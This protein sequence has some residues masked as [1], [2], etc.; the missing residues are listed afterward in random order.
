VEVVRGVDLTVAPGESVALVGPNGAGKT[1]LLHAL[2]GLVA[3]RGTLMV[4]GLHP[5][6]T[7]RARV[8][9]A[10]ALMPQRPVVPEG[11][12]VTDLVLLGRTPHLGRFAA[13]SAGDR[14]TADESLSRLGIAHLRDRRASELSGGELQRVVL[15]RALTQQPQ[16][17]L[18][19]EPTSSLDIGHQ[20]TVLELVDG[21]RADP[22]VTVVAAVHDLTL[23]SRYFARVVLL[24]AGRVVADGTPAAVLTAER[25]GRVYG[26]QVRV[27]DLEDGL[28]VLP[29]R[30]AGLPAARR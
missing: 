9:R 25:V 21:L 7:A 27:L 11:V 14:T 6:H 30:R 2:A 8:A 23:A 4:A 26:A 13:P 19:D 24:D 20:Q 15:A 5:H 29:V 17:L 28:V 1:T 12:T 10:V 16:V 18:L 3:S 22:G